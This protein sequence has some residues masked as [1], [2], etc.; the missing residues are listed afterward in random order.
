MDTNRVNNLGYSTPQTA[1]HRLNCEM[2]IVELRER[3]ALLKEAERKAEE[4]KRDQIL[5]EKQS[6]Q[7][8]LLD[9]LE[10]I[11]L[12]R[13]AQGKAALLRSVRCLPSSVNV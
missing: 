4:E 5:E 2:S 12:H 3:L 13:A 7:Q 9:T 6:Q 10:Q 8:L 11:S 1:G